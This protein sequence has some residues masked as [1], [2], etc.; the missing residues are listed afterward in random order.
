MVHFPI[1]ISAGSLGATNMK[2]GVLKFW[3]D[4]FHTRSYTYGFCIQMGYITALVERVSWRGTRKW[5]WVYYGTC[6]QKGH[7]ALYADNEFWLRN[8]PGIEW[9]IELYTTC[10]EMTSYAT[11][12]IMSDKVVDKGFCLIDKN[13]FFI[14]A[15][16]FCELTM[17]INGVY[18]MIYHIQNVIF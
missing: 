10:S 13:T 2:A 17:H 7:I 9:L 3:A 18:N 11:E 14:S 6:A 5:Y 8:C 16:H 4:M 1:N 12:K 15:A